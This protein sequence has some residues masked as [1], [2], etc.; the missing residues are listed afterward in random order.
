MNPTASN[1][2]W[3]IL[4]RFLYLRA[5]VRRG[6]GRAVMSLARLHRRSELLPVRMID[7]RVLYMDLREAMSMPYLLTGE[8]WGE[9]GET[10]LLRSVVNPGE[11]AFDIGANVGWY[12][13][14]LGELVGPQGRV[15]AFEPGSKAYRMLQASARAYPQVTPIRLA[16]GQQEGDAELF[17]PPDAAMASLR[18]PSL[19]C[20]PE[21]CRIT[22][23]D[24]WIA[25]A[26]AASPTVVKC[27][28]EG[29]EL[30]ILEGARTL[31]DQERPP[32]W[33]VELSSSA[34]RRFGYEA[35]RIFTLFREFPRA[36]YEV[37][38]INSTTEWLERPPIPV[39]FRYDAVFV[40]SWLRPRISALLAP[41]GAVDAPTRA[42]RQCT[43]R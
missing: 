42:S 15:Y 24:R 5:R 11:T 3:I 27:D 22:S 13:T 29:A 28:A 43:D 1:P 31:L 39:T 10:R 9:R 8:I 40:P 18:P 7:G 14:L 19:A 20:I 4:L 30:G 25:V 12:T 41:V 37:F 2:S 17:V 36:G 16:L 35:E 21:R 23:L 32:M 26:G 34:A 33:V 6:L 38:R